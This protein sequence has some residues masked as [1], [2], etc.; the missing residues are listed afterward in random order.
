[1]RLANE[2]IASTYGQARR[3]A[4]SGRSR[5]KKNPRSL[6]DIEEGT[7]VVCKC[8]ARGATPIVFQ[9]CK[10]KTTFC[11]LLYRVGTTHL[12]LLAAVRGTLAA[13]FLRSAAHEGVLRRKGPFRTFTLFRIAV[14]FRS[15]TLFVR[16]GSVCMILSV[17]SI[18][19]DL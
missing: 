18:P 2:A 1:M 3:N 11:W 13:G 9:S 16:R 14:G 7:R 19:V 10:R 4:V 12:F 8:Y 6:P 15:H 5:A 17:L